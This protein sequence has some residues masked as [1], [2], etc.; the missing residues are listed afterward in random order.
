MVDDLQSVPSIPPL[1]T[2]FGAPDAKRAKV[3]VSNTDLHDL[4]GLPD[5]VRIAFVTATADPGHVSIVLEGRGLP[6][7]PA[8][9]FN[10]PAM[11]H[12]AYNGDVEAPVLSPDW[13]SDRLA[14]RWR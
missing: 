9:Y 2:A 14:E 6:S 10:G 4:L 11:S 1:A 13:I 7:T 8:A 12:L 5:D 3:C